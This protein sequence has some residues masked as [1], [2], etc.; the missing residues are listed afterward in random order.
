M[1]LST[2]SSTIS[3]RGSLGLCFSSPSVPK[4]SGASAF[5]RVSKRNNGGSRGL[6]T[7]ASKDANSQPI[8]GALFEPFEEVKKELLL[9]PN[10]PQESL[11]R[12]MYT[13]QCEKAI[14]DQI[15]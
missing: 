13:D 1:V 5:V 15:K 8:F 9:V 4:I 12:Q 6:V 2:S 10:V 11:A 7:F 3:Q 14:N